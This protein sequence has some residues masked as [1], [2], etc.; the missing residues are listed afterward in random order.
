MH[1]ALRVSAVLIFWISWNFSHVHAEDGHTASKHQAHQ[2]MSIQELR[3]IFQVEHHNDVPPYELVQVHPIRRHKR[4]GVHSIH[5]VN[6][7]ASDRD[8]RLQLRRN[9]HLLPQ[10]RNLGLLFADNA[11][12]TA[13]NVS[14]AYAPE[15]DEHL[16]DV[17]QDETNE[18]ALLLYKDKTDDA[19]LM[20][21]TIGEDLVVKPISAEVR[22]RLQQDPELLAS[23]L[24]DLQ[25]SPS[26]IHSAPLPSDHADDYAFLD[27]YDNLE[28]EDVMVPSLNAVRERARHKRSQEEE[29]EE[30]IKTG[31]HIVYKRRDSTNEHHS[32]YNFMETD[33]Y[34][35]KKSG[36]SRKK[37]QAPYMIFPEILCIV[38]YDGYR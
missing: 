5:R 10:N 7:R 14:Y 27:E 35:T 1:S 15:D 20:D 21:G 9:E 22:R 11:E 16:G 34:P 3:R 30:S 19:L 37:R 31:F 6:F 29:E 28:D 24:R 17:F 4:S 13:H 2:H 33:Q 18:A 38:D 8:F 26:E 23:T 36:H 32:D 25:P 12:T